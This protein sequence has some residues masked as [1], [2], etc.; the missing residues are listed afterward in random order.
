MPNTIMKSKAIK[1]QIASITAQLQGL[2]AMMM[3]AK[4][5]EEV[6]E[7]EKARKEAEEQKKARK[8]VKEQEKARKEEM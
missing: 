6:E 5:H 7:K 1:E 4:E 3:Q 2:Q 8:E